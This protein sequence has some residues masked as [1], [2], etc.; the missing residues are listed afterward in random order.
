MGA[1]PSIL[2]ELV[3]EYADG[4]TTNTPPEDSGGDTWKKLSDCIYKLPNF[5]PEAEKVAFSPLDR[6]QAGNL[7]GALPA[8][9]GTLGVYP[10]DGFVEAYI[11]MIKS[12]RD[13]E[14]GN[15]FWFR[16]TYPDMNRKVS[17]R[18]NIQDHLPTSEDELGS[19]HQIELPITNVDAMIDS[20]DEK[21]T[22]GV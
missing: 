13:S 8:V 16:V 12:Q 4:T 14:K 18:M 3:I 17:G 15:C 2:K 22:P 6:A 21:I 20:V 11:A 1:L 7:M 5:F 10:T 9:D 19:L